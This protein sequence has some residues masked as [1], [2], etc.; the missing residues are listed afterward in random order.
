MEIWEPKP[1]GTLWAK[2]GL[3]RGFFTFFTKAHIGLLV[4]T[5]I[6]V[7]GAKSLQL[8]CSYKTSVTQK[9]GVHEQVTWSRVS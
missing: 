9:M 7:I 1:P 6:H 2:P 4:Q 8:V 5:T 3:L